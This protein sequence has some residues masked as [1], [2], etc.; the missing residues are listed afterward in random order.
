MLG[1]LCDAV[2]ADFSDEM[3]HWASGF[4]KTDG[5][6]AKY[7][8][9]SVAR[10]TSFEPYQPRNDTVPERLSALYQSCL[11]YYFQLESH[12]LY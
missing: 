8:Y 9:S 2:G 6:W 3:L 10:S 4:R 11:P 5:V 7:W 1:L 12:R